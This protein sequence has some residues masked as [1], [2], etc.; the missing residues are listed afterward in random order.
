MEQYLYLIAGLIL[1]LA[2]GEFL[3]RGGV[4]LAGHL[5][6]SALVVG[7]TVVSFG[8]SA[9]ELVVS[10]DAALSGHPDISLGNVIGSNI[11]NIGLVLALTVIITPYFVTTGKV[12]RDW[13]VMFLISLLLIFFLNSGEELTRI[14][15]LIMVVLLILFVYTVLKQ[16]RKE[17]RKGNGS[18]PEIKYT[19]LVSVLIIIVSSLSLVAGA[20]LLVSGASEIAR[21]FNVSERVIS[22]SIIALGTSLPELAT[23]AVAAARKQNEISIGNIIGSNIFNI[24]A[25]LGITASIAPIKVQDRQVLSFDLWYMLGVSLLLI[26]LILPVKGSYLRRWKGLI[27]ALAY[28]LFLFFVYL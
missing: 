15:G 27:L 13:A 8:T 3:V 26:L 18:P 2:G 1:L 17:L 22:V 7:V 10:L 28:I 16:S 20:K 24:L 25:I 19:V 5:K 11:S 23:S 12:V 21:D 4:S 9:P 14:E 6:V